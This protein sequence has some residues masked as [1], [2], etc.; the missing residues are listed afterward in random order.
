MNSSFSL[1]IGKKKGTTFSML[2]LKTSSA[3][4]Y[5]EKDDG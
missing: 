4:L 1:T 2:P 3:V 5:N